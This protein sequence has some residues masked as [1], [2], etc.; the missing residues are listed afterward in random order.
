MQKVQFQSF[1]LENVKFLR[2]SHPKFSR[3]GLTLEN[4]SESRRCFTSGSWKTQ[5]ETVA[6]FYDVYEV[7]GSEND[8]FSLFRP[9]WKLFSFLKQKWKRFVKE[10]PQKLEMDHFGSISTQI[11]SIGM[12]TGFWRFASRN[13]AQTNAFTNI[14]L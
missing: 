13:L 3:A 10:N 11:F 5:N 12:K 9:E 6:T 1:S 8:S 2:S 7:F 14:L 4:F